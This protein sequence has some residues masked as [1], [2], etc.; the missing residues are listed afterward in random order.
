MSFGKEGFKSNSG[1]N[2]RSKK[3]GTHVTPT[4]PV[5]QDF[6][7]A[8]FLPTQGPSGHQAR[9]PRGTHVAIGGRPVDLVVRA[10]EGML[11]LQRVGEGRHVERHDVGGLLHL[12]T[13]EQSVHQSHGRVTLGIEIMNSATG[14][15]KG[16]EDAVSGKMN[17][18]W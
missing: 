18:G 9:E 7:Q 11:C 1:S 8:E 15:G 3:L 6:Y 12:P 16:G 2:Q 10:D 5:N 13:I 4:T 17:P 14:G